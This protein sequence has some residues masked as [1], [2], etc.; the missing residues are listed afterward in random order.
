METILTAIIAAISALLGTV[1]GVIVNYFIE[2]NKTNNQ[3]KAERRK[4]Y[5]EF[6]ASMQDFANNNKNADM[7]YMFQKSINKI[8]LYASYDVA[9][10]VN[11]YYKKM[12][13]LANK[14]KG[15]SVEQHIKFQNEIIN[16][17]RKDL[18]KHAKNIKDGFIVAF[19]KDNIIKK[20]ELKN[21]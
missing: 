16:Q 3:I 15:L 10:T 8:L 17:M 9:N 21:E 13:E 7:F 11:N 1:I 14:E 18:D 19:N 12:T 20:E 5:M 4:I 2:K 6:I